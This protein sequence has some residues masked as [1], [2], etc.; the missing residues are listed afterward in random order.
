MCGPRI[1]SDSLKG[2]LETIEEFE[3]WLNIR[4]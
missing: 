1:D 3:Y 2:I 4:W